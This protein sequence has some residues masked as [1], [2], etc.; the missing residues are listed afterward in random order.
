MSTNTSVT[1]D[2]DTQGKITVKVCEN[3]HAPVLGQYCSQCGQSVEPTLQYFWTV[4]LHILDDIFSFDS[5]ATRT[6]IPLLFKPGFLTQKYFSGQR[7]H[8][9]PPL[10]LYLFISIVFFLSLKLTTHLGDSTE[11]TPSA[12]SEQILALKTYADELKQKDSADQ[13]TIARLSSYLMDVEAKDNA[14]KN[15]LA[16][17]LLTFEYQ[18]LIKQTE[19]SEHQKNQRKKIIDLYTESKK[20]SAEDSN[21]SFTLGNSDDGSMNLSFLS[22]KN[23]QLLNQNVK[24]LEQKITRLLNEDPKKLLQAAIAKLPQ[25]MF[26]ILPIFALLLKLMYLF[27]KRLYLEHL[28]V[29]LHSHSFIFLAILSSELLTLIQEHILANKGVLSDGID[30]LSFAIFLWIPVYLFIMQ[31]RIYQQGMLLTTIK[32]IFTGSVYV[33]LLT[34]TAVIALIWGAMAI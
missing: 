34:L 9:V 20:L 3:C 28:T 21:I 16:K 15:K 31:K 8:Y 13:A 2:A 14:I 5:R 23:N 25:L 29:A 6:L 22:E 26:V 11:L 18:T 17:Q 19:L 4:V 32:F 30:F 7:I 10:K 1:S 27:K 24:L 33:L 12:S